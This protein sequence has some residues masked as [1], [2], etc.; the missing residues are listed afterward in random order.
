MGLDTSIE[1]TNATH[2][3]WYGCKK[4]TDGC[5]NCYAERDMKRY[6]RDF[7]K[8]TKAK[9]FNKPLSWKKPQKVFVNSWSDFFIKEAD[10]WRGEAWEIIKKT[11]HLIYQILTKRPE[12]IIDCLPKDWGDGYSN[13]WLGITIEHQKYIRRLGLINH[14]PAKIKFISYEPALGKIDLRIFFR[15]HWM[16]DWVISGGESGYNSRPAKMEWFQSIRDQCFEFD[17]SYFHKQNGGNKKID[18]VWGGAEM[19]GKFYCAIPNER[20]NVKF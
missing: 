3:F 19:D 18:G 8:V 1:W 17:V 15:H 16:V 10:N 20:Y 4:I 11:P 6:G 2:N 12:R 9:G 13:V 5:K 14:I 7:T